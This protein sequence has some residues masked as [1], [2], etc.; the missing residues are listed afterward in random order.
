MQFCLAPRPFLSPRLFTDRNFIVG[1]TLY[2]IMGLIMYASLALLA[3]Y[4][5]TLMDYPVVTAGIVLAPRGAGLMLA[6]LICGRVI[7]KI[8]A[9]L[10]VGIGFVDRRLCAVRDDVWTPDVSEWTMISVGFIQGISIGF[11]TIPINIIAFATLPAEL[12]TEAT[13]IYSLM[14]NLGSAIGISI[15]GAL[16]EINTQVNHATIA[17]GITPF[18]RALQTG[19]ATRFWNPWSLHGTAMLD[20]EITR[21]AQIIAYVDDFK[22]MLVLA[23]IVLP[24]VPLLTRPSRSGARPSSSRSIDRR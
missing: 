9:R 10:L 6:A 16:L 3:P 11:L 20:R 18:N 14:R 8:S 2:A 19:A 17:E 1:V 5:Q 7:G 22:L 15:T 12:R 4:L 23:I 13:G 21:Q 24:L